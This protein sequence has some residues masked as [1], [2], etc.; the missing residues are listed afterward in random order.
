MNGQVAV[1][2]Q[3][4]VLAFDLNVTEQFS[5]DGAAS[6]AVPFPRR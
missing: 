2:P 1:V 5:W 6:K 4:T 3:E